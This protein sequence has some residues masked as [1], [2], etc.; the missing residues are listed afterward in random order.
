MARSYLPTKAVT[1]KLFVSFAVAFKRI[2]VFLP[3]IAAAMTLLFY[4]FYPQLLASWQKGNWHWQEAPG[5]FLI[6][7]N[8]L[9][10]AFLTALVYALCSMPFVALTNRGL[11]DYAFLKINEEKLRAR[12]G[13]PVFGSR[14]VAIPEEEIT[15]QM[16]L[17][18][19]KQDSQKLA[20]YREAYNICRELD[21]NLYSPKAIQMLSNVGDVY[22]WEMVNRTQEALIR[23]EAMPTVI[24]EA[25]QV[26]TAIQTSSM[27]NRDELLKELARAIAVLDPQAAEGL[28]ENKSD[29]QFDSLRKEIREL[30]NSPHSA[31]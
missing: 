9:F 25:K 22:A 15:K 21:E 29:K 7:I 14:I 10:S 23:I 11:Q 17:L 18:S 4:F 13:N 20:A 30:H 26:Y 6:L 2:G 8:G 31:V 24:E 3:I 12:L 27:N 28:Y 19:L 5:G 16:D 1:G